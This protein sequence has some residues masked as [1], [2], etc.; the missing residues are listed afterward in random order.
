LSGS[1]KEGGRNFAAVFLFCFPQGGRSFPVLVSRE[2]RLS[3]FWKGRG[4]RVEKEKKRKK[5][6]FRVEF[7]KGERMRESEKKKANRGKRGERRICAAPHTRVISRLDANSSPPDLRGKEK[8]ERRRERV[9]FLP[10]VES[11]KC[12]SLTISAVSTSL[13]KK[14]K[15]LL[16]VPL[17]LFRNHAALL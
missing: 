11:E 10:L 4:S 9:F 14:E 16:S 7:F 6:V 2:L 13:E 1:K 8:M 5:W 3:P 17:F 12:S 15:H